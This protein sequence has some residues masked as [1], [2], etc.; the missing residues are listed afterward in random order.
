MCVPV[1]LTLWTCLKYVYS[2]QSTTL[3][4]LLQHIYWK[5]NW[6]CFW[7]WQCQRFF[8]YIY[9]TEI[10]RRHQVCSD[11]IEF[12]VPKRTKWMHFLMAIQSAKC[13][14]H[15]CFTWAKEKEVQENSRQDTKQPQY[16]RITLTLFGIWFDRFN[17]EF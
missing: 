11:E 15:P 6:L 17:P 3:F 7:C 2:E 16:T 10:Y 9:G 13:W 4:A 1:F 5:W 12:W 14:L 8:F